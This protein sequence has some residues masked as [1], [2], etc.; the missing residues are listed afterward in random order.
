MKAWYDL[1]QDSG[2]PQGQQLRV[3]EDWNHL[4]QA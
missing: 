3:R 1:L 2:S 4:S